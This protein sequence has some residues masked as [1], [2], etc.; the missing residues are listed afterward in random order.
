[1]GEA[2]TWRQFARSATRTLRRVR[3]TTNDEHL[4]TLVTYHSVSDIEGP[5]TVS[6][7]SFRRQVQFIASNYRVVPLAQ[8]PE[9]LA[10][11][12][13]GT[14][15]VV[16][17]F[18]DAYRDFLENA[19]P[20]LRQ[21]QLHATVFV[22][23]AHIDGSNSWDV[24]AGLARQKPLLNAAQI[25]D[26]HATGLVAFGSH[27]RRHVRMTGVDSGVARL[28]AMDS[29]RDLER[30]LGD[31]VTAFAY[32]YG[33]LH[34][35]SQST[36]RIVRDA[37]YVLAVTAHWG[38]RQTADENLTLRR[39]WFRC[40]DTDADLRAMIDGDDD[41]MGVKERIGFGVRSTLAMIARRNNAG[42]ETRS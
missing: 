20:V 24:E 27:T 29:K 37:G 31:R 6:P 40:E 22:P 26:L 23:T 9:I 35:F 14:R 18:D 30:I 13:D 36:T 28:E 1:M 2:S 38:T 25:R 5:L 39:V 34:D 4:L 8:I 3:P 21:H 10:G 32:P 11:R 42:L 16:L 12:S 15:R 17:T 19:Y 41:W 7:E 33:Q